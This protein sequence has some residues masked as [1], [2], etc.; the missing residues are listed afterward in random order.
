MGRAV[1]GATIQ[2]HRRLGPGLLE[3]VYEAALCREV[4]FAASLASDESR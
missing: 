3:S 1:I 4:C 2:G